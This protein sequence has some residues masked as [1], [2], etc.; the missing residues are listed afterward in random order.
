M[1][2]IFRHFAI[3]LNKDNFALFLSNIKTVPEPSN[4]IIAKIVLS[5]LLVAS[6]VNFISY[7]N[8]PKEDLIGKTELPT[9]QVFEKI[10][11]YDLSPY[12]YKNGSNSTYDN[13]FLTSDAL[14]ILGNNEVIRISKQ[15]KSMTKYPLSIPKSTNISF[16]SATKDRVIITL[17]NITKDEVTEDISQLLLEFPNKIYP[18]TGDMTEC[19]LCGI[20]P[21]YQ[22][23]EGVS[24][25]KKGYGDGC[26]GEDEFYLVDINTKVRRKIAKTGG[27]CVGN[28][29]YLGMSY[30]KILVADFDHDTSNF[31]EI[32]IYHGLSAIDM[33]GKIKKLVKF[34]IN[35]DLVGYDSENKRVS[36]HDKNGYLKSFDLTTNRYIFDAL[37]KDH[38]TIK[39]D[40][41]KSSYEIENFVGSLYM[42]KN[43][44]KKISDWDFFVL[45]YSEN[46][47]LA[48]SKKSYQDLTEF[49]SIDLLLPLLEKYL[50]ESLS[51]IS[52]D[53]NKNLDIFP[54]NFDENKIDFYVSFSQKSPDEQ[55]K[56][57]KMRIN[58]ENGSVFIFRK[59]TLD[60]MLKEYIGFIENSFAN[61]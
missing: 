38:W 50:N 29:T 25:F 59:P 31:E 19:Y 32:P 10:P 15:D 43:T 6:I 40:F 4:R 58:T 54:K 12:T 1:K 53:V 35:I 28:N 39:R 47:I 56:V 9:S 42:E 34:S 55:K 23:S 51:D 14:Y 44:E 36:L 3:L 17:K 13:F 30:G 26:G 60:R 57:Y 45:N 22:V 33:N 7:L 18:I 24:L 48:K 5:I 16:I 20:E 41:K 46:K 49:L 21:I 52:F 2:K 11:L 61:K 37:R 8:T 27:G